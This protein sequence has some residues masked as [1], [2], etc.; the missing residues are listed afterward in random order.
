MESNEV[1]VKTKVSIE[2]KIGV[3]LMMGASLCLAAGIV[4]GFF[5]TPISFVEQKI[6]KV[7]CIESRPL[8]LE[9]LVADSTDIEEMTNSMG[10]LN[11]DLRQALSVGKNVSLIQELIIERKQ[12]LSDLMQVDSSAALDSVFTKAELDKVNTYSNNCTEILNT[13]DGKVY[14]TTFDGFEEGISKELYTFVSNNNRISL[15]PSTPPPEITTSRTVAQIVGY[16]IDNKLLFDGANNLAEKSANSLSGYRVTLEKSSRAYLGERKTIILKVDFANTS[17]SSPEHETIGKVMDNVDDYYVENSYN[18]LHFAGIANPTASADIYPINPNSRYKISMNKTCDHGEEDQ[19]WETFFEQSMQ[20][21]YDANGID[22]TEYD[23]VVAIA[24]WQHSDGDS[25]GWLGSATLGSYDQDAITVPGTESGDEYSISYMTAISEYFPPY[26]DPEYPNY[27]FDLNNSSRIVGHE[28][29]H[30]LGSKHAALLRCNALTTPLSECVFNSSDEYKDAHDIMGY[31]SM[32][33]YNALHKDV[34]G[35]MNGIEIQTITNSGTYELYPIEISDRLKL[36]AIKIPRGDDH[37]I[38]IE[39]RQPIGFDEFAVNWSNLMTGALIHTT[40]RSAGIDF[41]RNKSF[42]LDLC[43][44]PYGGCGNCSPWGGVCKNTA[45]Q[46]NNS[47]TDLET[48]VVITPLSVSDDSVPMEERKLT[49]EVEFLC[50]VNRD[51]ADDDWCTV[52][53]C[54]DAGT[55]D[56]HCESTPAVSGCGDRTCGFDSWAHCFACGDNEGLC[57]DDGDVCTDEGYCEQICEGGI[58]PGECNIVG[59]TGK[60]CIDGELVETDCLDCGCRSGYQCNFT[61]PENRYCECNVNCD[62]PAN[63]DH[64]CCPTPVYR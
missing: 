16:T 49:V 40:E 32:S 28:F 57:V 31:Y 55:P 5:S 48:G 59:D 19:I 52:D 36:K 56:A 12:L 58:L 53:T 9:K 64:P 33:H 11:I 4:V 29:G 62:N 43:G 50:K 14:I 34:T 39:Y 38:Y 7:T 61:D 60:I 18:Q 13:Y 23:H 54:V 46:L 10:K 42:L 21:A 8:V 2:E 47:W 6:V 17:E 35:W 44:P 3:A 30:N 15:F 26:E 22:F 37:Y 20:V 51:C 1:Q 25:C 24:P 63:D 41:H 27:E 45:L